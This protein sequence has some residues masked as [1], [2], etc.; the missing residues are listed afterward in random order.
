MAGQTSDDPDALQRRA[1]ELE[2]R[3]AAA[4]LAYQRATWIR[5][6]GVFFPIP[7]VVVLLRLDVESWTYYLWGG[8]ILLFGGLLYVADTAASGRVDRLVK[9]AERARAACDALETR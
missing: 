4:A 9:E 8:L 3:A 6:V 1:T 5:F 2:A 7:F